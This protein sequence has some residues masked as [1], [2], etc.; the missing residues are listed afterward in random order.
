[1]TLF[2]ASSLYFFFGQHVYLFMS[3]YTEQLQLQS[4]HPHRQRNRARHRARLE[5]QQSSPITST[6]IQTQEDNELHE[7]ET[8]RSLLSTE[9][10]CSSVEADIESM[11]T[12][13]PHKG[14]RR[15][16]RGYSARTAAVD[17]WREADVRLS[18]LPQMGWS[19]FEAASTFHE[20]SH[21]SSRDGEGE[22]EGH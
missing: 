4:P 7:A 15:R 13:L 2:Y 11:R 18:A 19:T 21:L 20:H 5:G 6:N 12:G 9:N 3:Q 8:Q 10:Q 22:G 17:L 1:M 14:A 16:E